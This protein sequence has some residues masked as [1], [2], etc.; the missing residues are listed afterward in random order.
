MMLHSAKVL[1]PILLALY[2][3]MFIQP[4]LYDPMLLLPLSLPLWLLLLLWLLLSLF[5]TKRALNSSLT[6]RSC[7]YSNTLFVVLN[8]RNKP[9]ICCRCSNIAQFK[10][11][12]YIQGKWIWKIFGNISLLP[13]KWFFKHGY[14]IMFYS[15]KYN[16]IISLSGEIVSCGKVYFYDYPILKILVIIQI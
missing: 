13:V 10:R 9:R 3:F 14:L 8:I 1:Q 5:S 2:T 7:H 16:L 11:M 12:N 4:R 6:M 15:V